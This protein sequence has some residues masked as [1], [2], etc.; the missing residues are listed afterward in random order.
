[1]DQ[2]VRAQINWKAE[3]VRSK[4]SVDA[5]VATAFQ[6]SKVTLEALVSKL[7]KEHPE[8]RRRHTYSWDKERVTATWRRR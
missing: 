6:A 4:R 8:L 3:M 1:V 7:R 5:I 2:G